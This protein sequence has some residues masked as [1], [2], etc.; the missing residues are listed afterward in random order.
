MEESKRDFE[1]KEAEKRFLKEAGLP[2]NYQ[3]EDDLPRNHD[4]IM[5]EDDYINQLRNEEQ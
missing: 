1:L 4:S 5:E 3:P 2:E